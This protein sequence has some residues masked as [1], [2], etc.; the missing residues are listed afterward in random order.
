M[1]S[2]AD[3]QQFIAVAEVSRD[4]A[5]GFIQGAGGNLSNGLQNYFD[6]PTRYEVRN[7]LILTFEGC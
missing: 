5:I 3:I 1:A 4:V 2:E 7:L 6:D